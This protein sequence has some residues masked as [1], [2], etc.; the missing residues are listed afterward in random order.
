MKARESMTVIIG[1]RWWF[2]PYLAVL[3]FARRFGFMPSDAHINRVVRYALR[4]RVDI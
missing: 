2:R 3:I 1:T 4:L